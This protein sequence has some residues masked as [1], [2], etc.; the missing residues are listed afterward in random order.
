MLSF[1]VDAFGVTR[2]V[3]VIVILNGV[4]FPKSCIALIFV[5]PYD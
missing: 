4:K 5:L 2:F 1:I 3:F